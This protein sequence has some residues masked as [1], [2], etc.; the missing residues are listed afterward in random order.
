MTPNIREKKLNRYLRIRQQ[1]SELLPKTDDKLARMA[2]IIALLHHK[3]DNFFWTGYYFI[4]DN[5]LVVGPY[6]GPVACQ[7]LKYGNGVCWAS[8]SRN[9]TIIVEDVNKFPGHIACDARSKSEIV[10]PVRNEKNEIVAVLDID[11]NVYANFNDIDAREL[12][13]IIAMLLL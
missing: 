7:E 10:V 5:K 9:E 2:T 13:R 3:M 12:E 11:S 4:R 1:L 6:Q 8:V